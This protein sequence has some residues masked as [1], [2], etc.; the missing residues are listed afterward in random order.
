MAC[1]CQRTFQTYLKTIVRR[2][3]K[4]LIFAGILC[5]SRIRKT[6]FWYNK[7]HD[8][9]CHYSVP[10]V[11][12]CGIINHFVQEKCRKGMK[13]RSR[14]R[15]R[16]KEECGGNGEIVNGTK[17]YI[18]KS[19]EGAIEPTSG[20]ASACLPGCFVVWARR[21]VSW[22]TQKYTNPTEGAFLAGLGPPTHG[23]LF[24]PPPILYSS[25]RGGLLTQPNST[26]T[27]THTHTHIHTTKPGP[28]SYGGGRTRTHAHTNDYSGHC[29]HTLYI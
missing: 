10:C 5:N 15:E 9:I 11:T 3:F 1:L 12:I 4:W 18:L 8:V 17:E 6:H 29:G 20:R 14:D 19:R 22:G 23:S 13:S 26:H 24:K 27:H 2:W 16:R 25:V 28:R 7:R 21:C